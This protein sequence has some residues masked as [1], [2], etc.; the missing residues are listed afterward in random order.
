M[1]R[2]GGVRGEAQGKH[3]G[4][5]GAACVRACVR[6]LVGEAASPRTLAPGHRTNACFQ[7]RHAL[8]APSQHGRAEN[9]RPDSTLG[10]E[11]NPPV[12]PQKRTARPG[13]RPGFLP[14][15]L[16]ATPVA[17]TAAP[18]T[19]CSCCRALSSSS[20]E[21]RQQSSGDA[22]HQCHVPPAAPPRQRQQRQHQQHTLARSRHLTLKSTPTVMLYSLR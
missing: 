10:R 15:S 1:Q 19:F 6:G 16:P 8:G 12:A 5:E 20:S 21:C 3:V 22:A 2:V 18:H 4:V 13:D 7:K 11:H 17:H 14:P 9:P